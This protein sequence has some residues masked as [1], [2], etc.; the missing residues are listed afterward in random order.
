MVAKVLQ[1]AGWAGVG[2]VA[3]AVVARFA[4]PEQPSVAWWLSVAGIVLLAAHTAG[5]WRRVAAFAGRRQTRYGAVATSGIVL[6]L[7]V[8]VAANYILS[9]RNV[10]WDLTAGGQYSLSDQT[11]RVLESLD[12]PV[13]V[14]VF[15]RADEF[16][17]YRDRL[18]EYEY[19][20]PQV[21]VEYVDVEGDP[22]R[23]GQYA[24]QSYGTIVFEHQG[25]VER[26]VSTSEQELTNALV[27]AVEGEERTVYFVQGHGERDP[28][29]SDREGYSALAEALARD[30]LA[31]E[32]VVL[33]QDG[34]VPDDA[35][36]PSSSPAR[37]PTSSPPRPTCCEGGW[38]G[39]G[40]C[41]CCSI[42]PRPRASRTRPAWWPWPPT[43][44]WRSA[45]TSSSTPAASGSCWARTQRCRWPPPTRR[46][47]S[48]TGST[49]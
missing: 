4:V 34:A 1:W 42:R 26:V 38:T 21:S 39:A 24:V 20:S 31:V 43:G 28:A 36:V 17:R 46:T 40:S 19:A 37:R 29:S 14:L 9:R 41:S 30:N 10:R 32:T 2:L 48:R 6:A 15:A 16:P 45:P 35:T 7:G 11:R 8:V 13:R 44:G 49:C 22:L 33:A 18:G 12:A 3:V 25:R 5:Q 47:P 23:A 27:K